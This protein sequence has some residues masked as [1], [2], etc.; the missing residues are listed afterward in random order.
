M[1]RLVSDGI[2]SYPHNLELPHPS[3]LKILVVYFRATNSG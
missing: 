1:L 2:L 3:Q